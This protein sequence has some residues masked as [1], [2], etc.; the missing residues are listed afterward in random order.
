MTKELGASPPTPTP[1]ESKLNVYPDNSPE[2]YPRPKSGLVLQRTLERSLLVRIAIP[3]WNLQIGTA[4]SAPTCNILLPSVWHRSTRESDPT[5]NV[6]TRPK[7]WL[8]RAGV[9]LPW[10]TVK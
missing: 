8:V 4:V 3:V 7:E 1:P 2:K 5:F 6:D 10:A 9:H